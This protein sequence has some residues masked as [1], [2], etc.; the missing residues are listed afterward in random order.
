MYQY[1]GKCHRGKGRWNTGDRMHPEAEHRVRAPATGGGGTPGGGAPATTPTTATAN[2]LGGGS[3]TFASEGIRFAGLSSMGSL[4]KFSEQAQVIPDADP[5]QMVPDEGGATG[6]EWVRFLNTD[7]PDD[8]SEETEDVFHD[9]CDDF[10]L[11]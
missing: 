11:N 6:P 3:V 1:C 10:H 8:E 2:H 4:M 9:C 7:D 5:V